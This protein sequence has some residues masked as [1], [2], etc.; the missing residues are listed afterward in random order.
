[1]ASACCL[2]GL[3]LI[4]GWMRPVEDGADKPSAA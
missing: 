2:A 4:K 1:M 3:L